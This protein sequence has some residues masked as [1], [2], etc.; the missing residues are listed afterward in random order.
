MP[1]DGDNNAVAGEVVSLVVF[2][3]EGVAVGK[4]HKASCFAWRDKARTKAFAI[5]Y[6]NE[7]AARSA[8]R[9]SETT[10]DVIETNFSALDLLTIAVASG[11][12]VDRPN[13]ALAAALRFFTLAG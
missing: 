7:L 4:P 8:R 9:G 3:R 13:H 11:P 1:H 5:D 12:F 2:L 6:E 10:G